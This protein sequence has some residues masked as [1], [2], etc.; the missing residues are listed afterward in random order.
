[1]LG[2]LILVLLAVGSRS[3]GLN[4][5]R[6]FDDAE[7]AIVNGSLGPLLSSLSNAFYPTSETCTDYLTI[8]Y[9]YALNCTDGGSNHSFLETDYIWASSSV[10]LVVEPNALQDLTCGIVDLTQGSLSIN[11][12]CLCPTYPDDV[13]SILRRLTAYVSHSYQ[14]KGVRLH[15]TAY[16][17]LRPQVKIQVNGQLGI[18]SIV[19]GQPTIF[20]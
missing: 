17:Y 15:Y 6:D 8:R 10:Y 13:T 11:L 19:N 18:F 2:Y 4:C 14:G 5:I 7:Q 16:N 3:L 12:Q 1:M 20:L 9:L